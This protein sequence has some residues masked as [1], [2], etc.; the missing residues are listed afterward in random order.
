MRIGFLEEIHAIGDNATRF[1]A[2]A[3]LRAL[4]PKA[5]IIFYGREQFARIF[6]HSNVFD[7]FINIDDLNLADGGGG[8]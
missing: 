6:F 7:R 4:Y 5:T 1:K 2:L 8:I 3:L